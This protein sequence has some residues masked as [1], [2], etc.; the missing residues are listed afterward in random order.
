M[1]K[2]FRKILNPFNRLLT[3]FVEY[4]SRYILNKQLVTTTNSH[5]DNQIIA[6]ILDGRETTLRR[7]Y[8]LYAAEFKAWARRYVRCSEADLTDAYQEALVAFYRNIVAGRLTNLTSSMKTYIF[9]IGYRQLK[10]ALRQQHQTAFVGEPSEAD[11]PQDP[12]FL[13]LLIEDEDYQAQKTHL[14]QALEQLSP[15]CQKVLELYFYQGYSIPQIKEQLNYQ[16]ENSVSVQKSRCLKSLK[17][18]LENY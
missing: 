8:P 12:H 5:S 4:C 11:L 17:E 15:A 18:I 7:I 14:G 16:S 3:N 1:S 6:E 9:A 13:Q 10:R 2:F